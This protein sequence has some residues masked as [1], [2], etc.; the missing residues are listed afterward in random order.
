MKLKEEKKLETLHVYLSLRLLG[1]LLLFFI[2]LYLL[3]S[4][5]FIVR[6]SVKVLRVPCHLLPFFFQA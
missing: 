2:I 1:L 5:Y 3:C 6:F 4:T